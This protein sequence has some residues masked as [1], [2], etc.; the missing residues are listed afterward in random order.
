MAK[1]NPVRLTDDK[2][3]RDIIV[4][5][6]IGQSTNYD[7]QPKKDQNITLYLHFLQKVSIVRNIIILKSI[8]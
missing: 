4:S 3:S 7:G 6:G 5:I 1:N 2:R 8:L